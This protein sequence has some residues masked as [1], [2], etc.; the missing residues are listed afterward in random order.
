MNEYEQ[1]RP[2]NQTLLR[3]RIES[4]RIKLG[5]QKKKI[6]EAL[7]EKDVVDSK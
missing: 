1:E 2:R 7:A 4:V 5:Y 3:E 6:R